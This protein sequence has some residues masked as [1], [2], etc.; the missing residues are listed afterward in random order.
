[1]LTLSPET[2]QHLVSPKLIDLL[3]DLDYHLGTMHVTSICRPDSS[4][5][6]GVL[7][8]RGIDIR[9]RDEEIATAIA[10]LLNSLWEYDPQRPHMNVALAHD[11]GQGM[12]LHLQV[13]PRT[14]LR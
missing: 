7:P 3:D 10:N 8:V 6:H 4:G 5:V 14:R 9:C 11:T 2:L 12:H 13:H 1:M